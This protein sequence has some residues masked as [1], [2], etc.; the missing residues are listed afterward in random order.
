MTAYLEAFRAALTSLLAH[1]MR[2]FL[3]TLG[4]LIGTASVIAVVSLIQAFRPSSPNSSPTS[5][6]AR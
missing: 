4:I 3:T 2:S 5:A 6:A 1:R